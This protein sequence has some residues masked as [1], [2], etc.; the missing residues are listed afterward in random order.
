MFHL[1]RCA[2]RM[3]VRLEGMFTTNLIAPATHQAPDHQV[4][5]W[6]HAFQSFMQSAKSLDVYRDSKIQ[7]KGIKSLV[8]SVSPGP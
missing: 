8:K 5:V 7:C 6:E 4:A 1:A 2:P 3:Q